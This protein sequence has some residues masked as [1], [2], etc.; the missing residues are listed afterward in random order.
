MADYLAVVCQ[1]K[2]EM[3]PYQHT[4][5]QNIRR[6]DTDCAAACEFQNL[7]V[8]QPMVENDPQSLFKDRD[9][10]GDHWASLNAYSL[11]L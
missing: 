3:K 2:S 11:M 4:G 6:L 5:L 7:L 9:S 10:L 8:I 1:L